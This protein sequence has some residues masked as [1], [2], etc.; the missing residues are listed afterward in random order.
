MERVP[1]WVLAMIIALVLIA[2]SV[3]TYVLL[4]NK[5]STLSNNTTFKSTD[6]NVLLESEYRGRLNKFELAVYNRY[7]AFIKNKMLHNFKNKNLSVVEKSKLDALQNAVNNTLASST[8]ANSEADSV[9]KV[10]SEPFK[11]VL[12][13]GKVL[14]VN[15]VVESIQ[16]WR[17]ERDPGV[18]KYDMT[19]TVQNVKELSPLLENPS[20]DD[21]E[22]KE[23][24]EATSKIINTLKEYQNSKYKS[25]AITA[26]ATAL[27]K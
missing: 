5:C 18:V 3:V 22:K 8:P 23:L 14:N 4:S 25:A 10:A 27:S 2:G 24:E 7:P 13:N 12:D 16:I 9:L 1:K 11:V 19:K 17:S 21:N 15:P 20:L 26:V 6:A